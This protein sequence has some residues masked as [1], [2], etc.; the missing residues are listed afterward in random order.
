MATTLALMLGSKSD[1]TS[2][3]SP[4]SGNQ[5]T[6]KQMN[7][8]Q[9][10][11]Q[12]VDL[13][14]MFNTAVLAGSLNH[15]ILESESG[16]N[17]N[18]F[19]ENA[20]ADADRYVRETIEPSSLSSTA[21]TNQRV[22]Q[23]AIPPYLSNVSI[24]KTGNA[25]GIEYPQVRDL[26]RPLSP[27]SASAFFAAAA[28][29]SEIDAIKFE[30]ECVNCGTQSTSQWRTNGNGHYLCNACGLYKKY[31]GEDR[32]PASIQQPR[33]RTVS[34]VYRFLIKKKIERKKKILLF[35]HI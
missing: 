30:R 16:D 18:T 6:S 11:S 1:S 2:G 24:G 14:T 21:F 12:G 22:Q 8:T 26:S 17:G 4:T 27:N 28:A 10:K 32:P 23:M 34:I 35:H 7:H 13:T 33:K 20:A 15:S 19:I 3:T 31:N 29:V 25:A 9:N 5:N